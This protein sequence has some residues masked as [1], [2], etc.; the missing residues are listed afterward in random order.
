MWMYFFIGMGGVFALGI[1]I[2]IIAYIK[3]KINA[4]PIIQSLKKEGVDFEK[5]KEMLNKPGLLFGNPLLNYIASHGATIC[6][7]K[8]KDGKFRVFDFSNHEN[9]EKF[10]PE[11]DNLKISSYTNG[12]RG[13]TSDISALP[14]HTDFQQQDVI[15]V[16]PNMYKF[17]PRVFTNDNDLDKNTQR[18]IEK[19]EE[20]L[21][22]KSVEA[23]YKIYGHSLGV[24]NGLRVA[25]Q[26]SNLHPDKQI[27]CIVK[28][29]PV[30]TDYETMANN[31]VDLLGQGNVNMDLIYTNTLYHDNQHTKDLLKSMAK[32]IKERS[33]DKDFRKKM[34][35]MNGGNAFNCKTNERHADE[36]ATK[37]MRFFVDLWRREII[38]Y[39]IPKVVMPRGG[40][41]E[42]SAKVVEE[43]AEKT[44]P[45]TKRISYIK[46]SVKSNLLSTDDLQRNHI[47]K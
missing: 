25:K 4:N 29:V 6:L 23:D 18:D 42:A 14:N 21:K 9:I 27:K 11:K 35:R 30:A 34:E 5:F 2:S 10:L 36:E 1:F 19:L 45:K 22:K 13:Y 8:Q 7:I 44:I 3:Q 43:N 24:R 41:N 39:I 28:N 40:S 38:S 32:V 12:Y 16:H 47:Y 26:L 33:A 17:F 31:I 37:D 15:L 46:K 20:V